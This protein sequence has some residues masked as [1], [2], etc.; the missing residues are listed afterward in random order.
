MKATLRK[1]KDERGFTILQSML[2]ISIMMIL[3]GLALPTF[4]DVA[5]QVEQGLEASFT[6]AGNTA[7]RLD[8]AKKIMAGEYNSPFPD[9]KQK[10]GKQLRRTNKNALEAMLQVQIYPQGFKWVF[11]QAATPISPPVVA[12]EVK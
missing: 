1:G 9:D 6:D 11:V 10:V 8:F 5:A 4:R 2:V 12:G 7:L 3:V